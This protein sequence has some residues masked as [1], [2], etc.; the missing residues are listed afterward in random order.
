MLST[1]V[2]TA[3]AYPEQGGARPVVI[4]FGA[5][6]AFRPYPMSPVESWQPLQLEL[7]D[8]ANLRLDHLKQCIAPPALVKRGAMSISRRSR[9][10][11]PIASL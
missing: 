8:Q 10:A 11:E 6:E 4:G 7:N 9:S 2:Q 3:D 1:P 5:I